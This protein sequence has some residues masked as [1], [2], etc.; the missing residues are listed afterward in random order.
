M[1]FEKQIVCP[2]CK[3]NYVHFRE[4]VN[5]RGNDNYEAW[6]GKG[7]SIEIPM[8]CE[9]GHNWVMVIGHHKGNTYTFNKIIE[10]KVDVKEVVISKV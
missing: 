7:S 2:V 1:E 10:E 8:F 4:A 3:F 9:E 6:V 5:K